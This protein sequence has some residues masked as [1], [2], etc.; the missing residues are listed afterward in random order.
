MLLLG[1]LSP[2][3]LQPLGCQSVSHTLVV[4]FSYPVC[5]T[6]TPSLKTRSNTN[7]GNSGTPDFGKC[8]TPEII[9]APGLDNRKET[10]FVA[11]NQSS[12]HIPAPLYVCLHLW[13]TASYPHGSAQ[14]VGIISQFVCDSMNNTCEA[15]PPAKKLCLQAQ[16]VAND[17]TPPKT[18]AQADGSCP[19]SLI[20][21]C[22]FVF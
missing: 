7:T 22:L 4:P 11:A 10:A 6:S 18:G 19:H 15:N 5:Q 16:A 21:R 17:V 2:I 20:P 8:S 13:S 3:R 12:R 1:A 14:N 9:F